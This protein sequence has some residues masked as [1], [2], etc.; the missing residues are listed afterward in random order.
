MAPLYLL[1]KDIEDIRLTADL[2]DPDIDSRVVQANQ[3]YDGSFSTG[4]WADKKK[5]LIGPYASML[6]DNN[7]NVKIEDASTTTPAQVQPKKE[8]PIWMMESTIAGANSVDNSVANKMVNGDVQ[9]QSSTATVDPLELPLNEEFASEQ[10]KEL[11]EL[12]QKYETS[13][14]TRWRRWAKYFGFKIE[15]DYEVVPIKE[16]MPDES[17]TMIDADYYSTLPKVKVAGSLLS[18][19]EIEDRHIL[20][21]SDFEKNE[22]IKI[23]QTIYSSI[24]DI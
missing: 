13:N 2:L 11:L 16:E 22:Y 6:N 1:L 3:T 14:E 7:F 19:T 18:M 8:Q 10:A 23:A 21:M 9:I 17:I 5:G 15:D 20:M 4:K 12:L 24:F